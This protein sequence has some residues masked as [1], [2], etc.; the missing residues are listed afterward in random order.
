MSAR[1]DNAALAVA[2]LS[3]TIGTAACMPAPSGNEI[4]FADEGRKNGAAAARGLTPVG[5]EDVE[6][7]RGVNRDH[8]I[9]DEADTFQAKDTIHAS[10]RVSGSANSGLVRAVWLDEKGEHLQD[11]TRIVSPSR[12]EIVSVQVS[13]PQGLAGG[14][15]R[16]DIFLDDRLVESKG[17]TVQGG[18]PEGP[19]PQQG[20]PN[21]T[22]GH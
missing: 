17:F 5:L 11:D 20:T 2:V 13:R 12:G 21:P 14:R 8:T 16:L 9:R 10:I 3:F 4:N 6:L 7:G 22:P 15:Y 19:G 1:L 18:E